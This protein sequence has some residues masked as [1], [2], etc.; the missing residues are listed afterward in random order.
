MHGIIRKLLRQRH[1]DALWSRLRIARLLLDV[2]PA[3]ALALALFNIVLGLLPVV[4]AVATSVVVARLGTLAAGGEA[5]VLAPFLTSAAAFTAHQILTPLQTAL[6]ELVARRVDRRVFSQLMT[7]ALRPT[8][9]AALEDQVVRDHLNEAVRELE[10]NAHS[11]GRAG[12]GLLALIARYTQL[13]GYALVIGWVF[14]WWAAFGVV[15]T[16]LLF[17]QGQRGGLRRY[18]RVFGTVARERRK[19]QYLRDL[20]LGTKA[21]KEIR[22]FGLVGW[23]TDL[24]R[25]TSRGWLDRVWA[26][27]RRIYGLPYLWYTGFGV[28]AIGA[29]LVAVGATAGGSASLFEL[30]LV[31][32]C[33][34]QAVRLGEFYP[35]CDVQTQYGMI[36]YEATRGFED[37]IAA[38]S[39]AAGPLAAAETAADDA[40]IE[41]RDVDFAYAAAERPV[42]ASLN[43]TIRPGRCT[44]VVGVNGAGKTTLV[45]LLTRLYEPTGGSIRIGGSDIRSFPP[46]R[47]RRRFSVV[48]QDFL[49]YEGTVEENI[50][51]G[52][53]EHLG[54]RDGVVRAAE[55]AGI[56]EVVDRL[57][58]GYDT[59]LA[60]HR[61]GGVDLS[62]GQWQRIA[63]ARTL[64]AIGHGASIVV[65]DEPT[66]SLDIQAEAGFYH[67]FR[68]LAPDVTTILISHR[69]PTVRHAD[70]IVVLDGGRVAEQGDHAALLE[71]DGRYAA[72]FREQAAKFTDEPREAAK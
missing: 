3:T 11:P 1:S 16:C 56:G 41:F 5:G 45:K 46:D 13:T 54:D 22:V 67:E 19:S 23:L 32:L 44:A 72:L 53:V 10:F 39:D 36:S 48:F 20:A 42:F 15:G 33:A 6:G 66:A 26:E 49:R 64:F 59:I 40:A 21:G 24:Y 17:R 58:E 65:L 9:I 50:A 70:D 55:A 25:S 52:A 38:R 43:L 69:F 57:P 31:T 8:G 61:K 68:E 30:A 12:A 71:A 63:I 29:V 60:P 27:R 4:F 2:A 47:Y 34:L 37:L 28:L 35:E 62:G 51:Y 7:A 18:A 14:A